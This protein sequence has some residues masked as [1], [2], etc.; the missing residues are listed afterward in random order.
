[1]ERFITK[2]REETE[3]FASDFA[4]SL[5]AGTIILLSGDLGSGKTVFTKGIVQGRGIT[6]S[7]V[8]PTFTIMNEYGR[9]EVYHFDLYRLNSIDE[10]EATGAFEQ[11]YSSAISVV[12]WPEIVGLDYFPESAIVVNILKKSDTE[13]EIIIKRN[14]L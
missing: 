1:M 4:K 9:G 3:K 6:D 7:V 13:R 11:L 2:S 12:E 14:D 8:S 10:F 5:E